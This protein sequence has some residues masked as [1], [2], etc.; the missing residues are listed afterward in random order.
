MQR[1]T[2]R[3]INACPF[4]GQGR[5]VIVEVLKPRPWPA[6]HATGPPNGPP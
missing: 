6:N 1:L 3:D 4:C 5:L 2:G